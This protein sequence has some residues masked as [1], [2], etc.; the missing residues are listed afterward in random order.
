ML[1][2]RATSNESY[3]RFIRR[4]VTAREVW[5]LKSSAGWAICDSNE[6]DD[7]RVMP[8][9]SD[10]AYA[11]RA[12]VD[13]WA[14]Y[15]PAPLGL[16]DFVDVWLRGMDADET[17]VGTNWDANNCGAEIEP[18]ELARRLIESTGV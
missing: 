17:L 2:D 15:E 8:F 14:D 10:R 1:Q 12:A 7:R 5:G 3:E 16:D 11:R 9:W 18:A 6:H 4:V 13:E